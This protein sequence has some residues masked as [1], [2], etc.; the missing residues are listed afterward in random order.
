MSHERGSGA[1]EAGVDDSSDDDSGVDDSSDDEVD[2]TP[3][4][5]GLD[6]DHA[7]P[8]HPDDPVLATC[9]RCGTYYCARCLEGAGR[10]SD[11]P[12]C[13]TCQLRPVAKGIGG[14]LIFPAIGLVI[15]PITLLVN[16]ATDA[17]AL[18]TTAIPEVV[19]PIA[20]ELGMNVGL[21]VYCGFA[22]HAF[23]TKRRRARLL[24]VGY[25]A[26]GLVL[27][28]SAVVLGSWTTAIVGGVD[29]GVG[30]EVFRAIFPSFIWIPYFLTSKRVK[31]TFVNP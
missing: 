17:D 23:F 6:E 19:L 2:E 14:F 15:T 24:M 25:Y 12:V 3:D 7:C 26:A 31:E 5:A 27:V 11:S 28:A 29:P 8:A 18:A 16:I 13:A 1:G 20:I 21:L 9:A 10:P 22:A 30:P 4:E